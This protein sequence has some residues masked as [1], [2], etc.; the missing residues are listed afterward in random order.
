MVWAQK[1]STIPSTHQ[2]HLKLDRLAYSLNLKTSDE[3]VPEGGYTDLNRD[4]LIV[5][6]APRV[7]PLIAQ[8][9]GADPAIKWRRSEEG[10]SFIDDV[11]SGQQ[12]HSD[13]DQKSDDRS[14]ACFAQHRHP[15]GLP[16]QAERGLRQYHREIAFH[17][18]TPPFFQHSVD[19]ETLRMDD[20]AMNP[21]DNVLQHLRAANQAHNLAQAKTFLEASIARGNAEHAARDRLI[22]RFGA[23][24]ERDDPNQDQVPAHNL[25][26]RVLAGELLPGQTNHPA[27]T[28]EDWADALRMIKPAR[29]DLNRLER[30]TLDHARQ[31]GMTWREIAAALGLDSPQAAH[32]RFDRLG[33]W[34]GK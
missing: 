27:P 22:R 20:G 25:L 12:F 15:T 21:D 24:H 31:A 30:A 10:H 16:G 13:F 19:N 8:A 26:H 14:R 9:I 32:Q 34:K 7:T 1:V 23:A 18:P 11:R 6:I 17:K 28:H 5:M 29:D 4:N 33:P 2:A 3:A